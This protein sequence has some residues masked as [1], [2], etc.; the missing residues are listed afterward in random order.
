MFESFSSAGTAKTGLIP[1]PRS[2][3]KIYGGHA[4]CVVGYDEQTKRLKFKSNW[5]S[6]WGT[7]AM[8]IFPTSTCRSTWLTPGVS[9]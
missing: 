5:G 1:M 7:R 4:I 6:E 9:S 2:N 8:A 3:E